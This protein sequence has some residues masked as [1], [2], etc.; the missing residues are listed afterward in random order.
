MFISFD[1]TIIYFK[2]NPVPT[3]W[4]TIILIK[5]KSFIALLRMLQVCI[6]I[7][8]KLVLKYKLF[9]LDTRH[10]GTLYVRQQGSVVIFRSQKGPASKKVW[11]TLIPN[12]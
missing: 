5:V 8:L 4:A 12:I 7:C 6:S 3:K 9:M 2:K 1:H 10:S 11:E